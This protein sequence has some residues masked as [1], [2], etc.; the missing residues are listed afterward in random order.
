MKILNWAT[1][2]Q[3]DRLLLQGWV[4]KRREERP[5]EQ[6]ILVEFHHPERRQTTFR[7]LHLEG[8]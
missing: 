2:D 6:R 4:E 3:V 1:S 7:S 5:A 8:P